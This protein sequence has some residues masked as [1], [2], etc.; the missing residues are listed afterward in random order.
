MNRELLGLQKY[1]IMS[2]FAGEV[3]LRLNVSKQ[4]FYKPKKLTDMKKKTLLSMLGLMTAGTMSA[5]VYITDFRFDPTGVNNEGVVV[6]SQDQ[7]M[8][9]LLWDSKAGSGA[10]AVTEIGGIS[11]GQ[12]IGGVARFSGDGKFVTAPMP[13]DSIP[14]VSTWVRSDLSDKIYFYNDIFYINDYYLFTIGSS[15]DGNSGLLLKSANKGVSWN[16]DIVFTKKGDDGMYSSVTPGNLQTFAPLSNWQYLTGGNNGEL[17]FSQN[18]GTQWEAIDLQPEGDEAVVDVYKAMDF[19]YKTNVDGSLT[20]ETAKYG[21][22]GVRYA[23]GSYAVWRTEDEGDTFTKV[24]E[25]SG[26]PAHIGHAGETFFMVTENGHI[27]KSADYG[28]TWTDVFATKDNASLYRIKFADAQKGIVTSD[29]VVYI[30]KDGGETWTETE[31]MPAGIN[32]LADAVAW[33]DAAWNGDVIFVVGT[34]GN[35]FKSTDNGEKFEQVE[36]DSEYADNNYTV[37]DYHSGV[38]N[39]MTGEGRV[40]NKADKATAKGYLA[41]V[42]DIEKGEWTPLATLGYMSGEA[43]SSPWQFSGDGKTVVG[44]IYNMYAPTNTVQSHASAMTTE[45][46]ID[47]G[48]KFADI[49]RASHAQGASYDASVI[50]GWQD[51]FGPRYGTVWIKNSD[52]SYTQKMM[53]KDMTKN[54]DDIDYNDKSVCMAELVGT[55]RS[56]SPDGKW[57]GGD[58]GELTAF[59]SPW[60]WSEET[61]YKELFEEAVGGGVAAVSNNGE[62]AIGWQGLNSGAWLYTKE[63]GVVLL[64][65]YVENVLGADL[66]DFYIM[67]AYDMSPNGRYITGFGM[68]GDEVLGYVI[69]LQDIGTSIESKTVEQTKASV[70]PNPVADELHIDMPFGSDEVATTLTLVDMQGRVVRR[71]D[72][73]RQSNTMDVS[74]LTEGIYVLDVNARGTHKAF[75]IMI[76]H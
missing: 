71:I 58:G 67:S 12:V 35:V 14:L 10:N 55:A 4:I 15:A 25:I 65:D 73:A 70:Y 60:L 36:V 76:K 23:D 61:G 7:N 37:V 29:G 68:R 56:V 16:S 62:K 40:Y 26:E 27:Q 17:Y 49:N 13:Y 1:L 63:D 28:K 66:G 19:M 8:P 53:L 75:K 42:Y 51:I 39:I 59:G 24:T 32:P 74:N 46:C 47:L 6:G 18:R 9:I 3:S 31:V 72:T 5:Q 69:D 48:S 45:E 41:G 2:T 50:V 30:T 33:N 20:T 52:G 22:I 64:Q 54:E 38:C 21:V 57:I 44:G 43:A 11:A 34:N